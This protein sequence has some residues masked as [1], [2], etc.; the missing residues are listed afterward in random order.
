[1]DVDLIRAKI[2]NAGITQTQLSK[3]SGISREQISRFLGG[4][5]ITVDNL[6]KLIRA[7]GLSVVVHPAEPDKLNT[8]FAKINQISRDIDDLRNTFISLSKTGKAPVKKKSVEQMIR[9][10]R[11][12][13]I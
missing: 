6:S 8:V 10:L 4:S 5:N 13:A 2:K 3:E 9:E 1:V 11:E 12:C 7:A